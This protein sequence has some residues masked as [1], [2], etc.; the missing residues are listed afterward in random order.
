MF[1]KNYEPIEIH[2]QLCGVWNGKVNKIRVRQRVFDFKNGRINIYNEAR[3]G[4]SSLVTE[5]SLIKINEKIRENRRTRLL[6]FQ[7]ISP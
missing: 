7:N 6:N 1:A 4:Q 2:R 5:D 3:T